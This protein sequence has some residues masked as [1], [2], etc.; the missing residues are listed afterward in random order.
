MQFEPNAKIHYHF[1]MWLEVR[2]PLRLLLSFWLLVAAVCAVIAYTTLTPQPTTAQLERIAQAPTR[3]LQALK[4]RLLT[5]EGKIQNSSSSVSIIY[6]DREIYCAEY[7]QTFAQ[8]IHELDNLPKTV[9]WSYESF[10]GFPKTRDQR[11]VEKA[12]FWTIRDGF[13]VVYRGELFGN[14]PW[15]CLERYPNAPLELPDSIPIQFKSRFT[16]MLSLSFPLYILS[17]AVSSLVVGLRTQ[18]ALLRVF[19][20]MLFLSIMIFSGVLSL[21]YVGSLH[22]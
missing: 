9:F 19:C 12:F 13:G 17:L 10:I 1:G 6:P 15:F 3:L 14:K 2:G 11:L 5:F 21:F 22:S 4:L 8:L 18:F 7:T 20:G 16:L